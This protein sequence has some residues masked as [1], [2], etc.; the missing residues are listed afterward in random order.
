V[1]DKSA[2]KALQDELTTLDRDAESMRTSLAGL[3]EKQKTT[4]TEEKLAAAELAQMEQKLTHARTE[5]ANATAETKDGLERAALTLQVEVDRLK[6]AHDEKAL[7][8]SSANVAYLDLKSRLDQA[9]ASQREK[10][11]ALQQK[12]GQA[13]RAEENR[14]LQE[15]RVKDW[16]DSVVS[17]KS[18]LKDIYTQVFNNASYQS[19]LP[20]ALQQLLNAYPELLDKGDLQDWETY[21][22]PDSI[23]LSR[24][25]EHPDKPF[26]LLDAIR[27]RAKDVRP[28]PKQYVGGVLWFVM[29]ND[30]PYN[31]K[32]LELAGD[33]N[34]P[35]RIRDA[36][37]RFRDSPEA[38]KMKL[39]FAH[40]ILGDN[41]DWASLASRLNFPWQYITPWGKD[42]WKH[43]AKDV[44]KEDARVQASKLFANHG[45][46]TEIEYDPSVEEV[47]YKYGVRPVHGP[48]VMSSAPG[49]LLGMLKIGIVDGLIAHTKGEGWKYDKPFKI[50][51]HYDFDK[52]EFVAQLVGGNDV[53]APKTIAVSNAALLER[54]IQQIHKPVEVNGAKPSSRELDQLSHRQAARILIGML[55][56]Q[57]RPND[58]VFDPK[59]PTHIDSFWPPIEGELKPWEYD[60]NQILMLLAG[61]A[62]DRIRLGNKTTQ[63]SKADLELAQEAVRHLAQGL[64]AEGK[65]PDNKSAVS[66]NGTVDLSKVVPKTLQDTPIFRDLIAGDESA[67]LERTRKDLQNLLEKNKAVNALWHEIAGTLMRKGSISS[68]EIGQ[69]FAK[70]RV[71]RN[72]AQDLVANILANPPGIPVNESCPVMMEHLES[73]KYQNRWWWRR[74]GERIGIFRIPNPHE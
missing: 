32:V 55:W 38:E 59:H 63:L 10:E 11:T 21:A 30:V 71:R 45:I 74:L 52:K 42:Q 4:E 65:T 40:Q 9:Y 31:E 18:K 43:F 2:L 37:L 7:A 34:D 3:Q 48:R 70:K 25:L 53:T 57:A 8:A 13:Q 64:E 27:A 17:E 56:N 73:I 22:P 69:L 41:A 62:S 1:V 67:T 16:E 14:S 26:A 50:K 51:V 47:L 28:E 49:D 72:L 66:P 5:A 58:V 60:R 19:S 35:D 15:H 39:N 23:A 54:A 44:L 6:T 61:V 36:E 68:A 33:T 29:G 20:N 24:M 46:K 12:T